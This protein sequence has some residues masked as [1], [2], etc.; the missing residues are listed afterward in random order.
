MN[1]TSICFLVFGIFILL[2]G[3][4]LLFQFKGELSPGPVLAFSIVFIWGFVF[5]CT[6]VKNGAYNRNNPKV[7]QK[8]GYTIINYYDDNSPE[9]WIDN[10]T[11]VV[12]LANNGTIIG[13]KLHA[14]G[15]PFTADEIEYKTT[16]ESGYEKPCRSE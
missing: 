4:I 14:D 16:K 10:E 12:Y 15:T 13:P 11:S 3:M 2:L 1:T 9:L 6:S 8:N 7:Q 5:I